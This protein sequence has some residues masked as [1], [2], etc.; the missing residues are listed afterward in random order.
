M[1][2]MSVNRHVLLW[3]YMLPPLENASRWTKMASICLSSSVCITLAGC[4]ISSI[5]FISRFVTIDLK[6]TLYAMFPTI[7]CSGLVYVHIVAI[8]SRQN[9]SDLF[10]KLSQIYQTSESLH[11]K[12]NWA[13][14]KT[15]ILNFKIPFAHLA[16]DEKS[17]R[18]L[19]LASNKSNKYWQYYFKYVLSGFAMSSVTM[20]TASVWFC[21]LLNGQFDVKYLYHPHKLM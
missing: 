5:T 13:I 6:D 2:P 15:A 11:F 8:L 4:V 3:L 21:W 9:I 19:A 14:S 10:Q 1:G 7:A 16:T 20:S 17:Y 12:K 18:F